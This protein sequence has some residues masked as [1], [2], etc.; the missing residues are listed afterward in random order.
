MHK[1][2]LISSLLLI[3]SV[4]GIS[5]QEKTDTPPKR[6]SGGVINGKALK[7]PKPEYPAEAIAAQIS[8]A[9]NVEIIISTEGNVISATAVSGHPLLRNPAV[10][11]AQQAK[12]ATTTLEGVPVEVS[13]IIVYNFQGASPPPPPPAQS[14]KPDYSLKLLSMGIGTLLQAYQYVG[15]DP[16]FDDIFIE[17]TGLFANF[18]KNFQLEDD[19]KSKSFEEKK[20][21]VTR[22]INMFEIELEGSNLWQFRTGGIIGEIMGQFGKDENDIKPINGVELKVLLSKLRDLTYSAPA[23]VPPP[24]IEKLKSLSK[25]AD[26][27]DLREKKTQQ[28]LAGSIEEFFKIIFGE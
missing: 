22:F 24:V 9:V 2:L 16:E 5:A 14:N 13:G 6:I 26:R 25:F 27:N 12:F 15:N 1:K 11:A 7:L 21:S 19:F 17:M 3:L 20:K 28:E 4:A 18:N 10:E 8:G 23:D